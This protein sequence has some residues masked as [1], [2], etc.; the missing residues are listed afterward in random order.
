MKKLTILGAFIAA[1]IISFTS[2]KKTGN[3][4]GS[5]SNDTLH[6]TLSRNTV[7]YNG[8]DYVAITVKN[9]AGEDVTANCTLLQNGAVAIN[10]KFIPSGLGT[11]TITA[12]KGS[13]PSEAKTLTVTQK[14]PSPF[15]QKILVEDCTGAWCGYC[16][17]VAY[18]LDTF[19]HNNPRCI[20]TTVHGGGSTDPY[21]F[22][23]YST[24]NSHYA[25]GGYPTAILNR[26]KQISGGYDWSEDTTDLHLALQGWAPLGLAISSSVS[27]S[28]VSGNVKVKF[29]VTTDKAMKVIIALVENGLVYP[30]TNYYS[31]SGGATPYLYGGANPITNFV[32]NGVLRKTATDL[33]GDAISVSAET[34]DNILDIP[35]NMTLSGS[36]AT[37][38]YTAVAANCAIVAFVVDGSGQEKGV[39]NVQYAPVGSTVNFD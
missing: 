25:V 13:M 27:G 26:K 10:S 3:T 7:E 34:K 31:P 12:Q 6:I 16:P 28:T 36:T 37:G 29:N 11:F 32:H 20:S 2:C 21:K 23:Y 5:G 24:F 14:S 8:F 18:L 22:Q 30:Q 33:F 19:K 17:R 1:S 9:N 38:T 4:T 15:S 35:F 39:Y